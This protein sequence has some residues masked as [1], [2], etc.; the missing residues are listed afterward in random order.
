MS[1][2]LQKI[3]HGHSSSDS[4]HNTSPV[5]VKN[6]MDIV[7][8]A[9]NNQIYPTGVYFVRSSYRR[10]SHFNNLREKINHTG[11]RLGYKNKTHSTNKK[12][13]NPQDR[14]GNI[15]VCFN[16]GCR[17]HWSYDCP[18]GHS[19]RNR[20]GVKIEEDLSLSHVVLMSQQKT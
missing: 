17:F 18:Y 10:D 11:R 8:Y 13:L 3:M 7:N 14:T 20:Y 5:M 9:E 15:T 12:K 2:Q 16:C 6:E 19:S 4:L 1:E